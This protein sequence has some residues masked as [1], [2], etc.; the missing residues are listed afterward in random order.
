MSEI[1]LS[2]GRLDLM[3]AT[4]A[5]RLAD[6]TDAAQVLEARLLA[7]VAYTA[8][9]AA[10]RL[11]KAQQAADDVVRAAHRAAA[12]ALD[13]ETLAERRLAE[14]YDAAREADEVAK[15]GERTDLRASQA[16]VSKPTM[17][18]LGLDHHIIGR[19]R[20]FNKAEA[21]DPGVVRR[22]LDASL[23]RGEAPSKEA[24]R[25][26]A[27]RE[28]VKPLAEHIRA[29][30]FIFNGV[31]QLARAFE[32]LAE[33]DPVEAAGRIHPGHLWKVRE[34]PLREMA[35]WIEAFVQQLEVA[36]ADVAEGAGAEGAAGELEGRAG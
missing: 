9:Q 30:G 33:V 4:A 22:T 14:Q 16:Q 26:A 29:H 5:K 7:N 31:S 23:A 11:A 1:V 10:A 8:A 17:A 21:E 19:G 34:L 32:P 18:D 12:D 36:D 27:I 28:A 3:V 2:G 24:L 6:A 25:R 35:A 13:I 15:S 20:A